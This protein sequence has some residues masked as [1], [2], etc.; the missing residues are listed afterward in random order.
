M[1]TAMV[2]LLMLGLLSTAACGGPRSTRVDV[3][4]DTKGP[5]RSGPYAGDAKE[6][7]EHMVQQI[8][9]Q[10]VIEDY[11]QRWDDEPPIVAMIRPVNNTRFVEVTT[12]FTEDLLSA[13]M[14]SFTR[15]DMRFVDRRTQT[16]AEIEAEK[17]AKE[18]GDVTDRSGRRTRLG[19]DFFITAQFDALSATDG[20]Q[21]DDTVKYTYQFVDAE[22]SE[23]LFRSSYD[24]RRVSEKS[25][26]YR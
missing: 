21:D 8:R 16:L 22:T 7:S 4:D 23:V 19:V 3:R 13:L 12:F 18:A 24:I 5:A 15:R 11:K 26:V 14:E 10:Q 25:A 17:T 20:R 2:L 6:V 1:R 9:R